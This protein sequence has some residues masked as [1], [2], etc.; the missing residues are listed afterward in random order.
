MIKLYNFYININLLYFQKDITFSKSILK[1]ITNVINKDDYNMALL[2]SKYCD[3]IL[4]KG[5]DKFIENTIIEEIDNSIILFN[6]LDDKDI[7]LESYRMLLSKR[8]LNN[9]S[10]SNDDEKKMISKLKLNCGNQNVSNLV[11][12]LN[13]IQ[14]CRDLSINFKKNDTTNKLN[15]CVFT[16]GF[17][18]TYTEIKMNIPIELQNYKYVF[19]EYYKNNTSSKKLVWIYNLGSCELIMELNNKQ[20]TIILSLLQLCVLLMFNNTIKDKSFN[21]IYNNLIIKVENIYGSNELVLK[22]IL[23]SLTFGKYKLLIKKSPNKLIKNTDIF[24]IN[25]KFKCKMNRFK[26]SIPILKENKVV[27]KVEDNRKF[28]IESYIVRIM[29]SRKEL[30]HNILVSELCQQITLFTPPIKIIKRCIEQLIDKEYLERHNEK[31]NVYTY[32]S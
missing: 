3:K 9:N 25:T 4:K 18:P 11:G 27:K 30:E 24:N 32:L 20:Y 10:N 1:C 7:F 26:M 2:L 16:H 28:I 29:K 8:L 13:D 23:H 12:M 31:K 22:K 17:W 14:I 15:V 5:A 21:E 19:E 6:C